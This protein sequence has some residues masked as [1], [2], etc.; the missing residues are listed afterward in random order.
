[1]QL[2]ATDRDE[3]DNAILTYNLESG[4]DGLFIVDNWT[5][6]ISLRSNLG[7]SQ[8]PLHKL[9]ISSKDRGDRRSEN[10]AIVEIIKETKL[11][12]LEF[13]S[14]GGY[15]FQIVEDHSMENAQIGREVGRTQIRSLATKITT[16]TTTPV[17]SIEYS[18]IYGDPKGNFKIDERTGIIT[19]ATKIDREVTIMYTLTVVARRGLAYGKTTANVSILDLNDNPP[20]FS[21][22]RDDIHLPENTAVGQE[23]YLSRARDKDSGINSR[24][25]YSITYNPDD[26]FRIN[27]AT[28]VVYLNR[29]IRA[30]PG[31]NIHIE[32]TATDGGTPPLSS[33]NTL[34]I[35]IADVNDH[36]PVFDHT[37]YET[38]LP[39][40]T[41]VNARFF[42]LGAS[43]ADLNENGRISYVISE[44]NSDG[45]FGI[46]PDG[47][48]FV[49]SQLDR[50][51]HD[52]YSLTISCHDHGEPSRSS[53]VPVIIRYVT[54]YSFYHL[55]SLIKFYLD[56]SLWLCRLIR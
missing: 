12:E 42:A 44:G 37:S 36:T 52:Y 18:I 32:L 4:G 22:D 26:H 54:D 28:G 16:T 43:D 5:G 23:I 29:P 27:E 53:M 13:D 49:K 38:S 45:K 7:T 9:V 19:T 40:S 56:F 1:M 21:R 24:V 35:T 48:L 3:G 6:A 8:K 51:E 15:E 31:T 47:Y 17:H 50:E 55:F 33:K 10:D 11:E 25:T 20:I 39:E 41:A 46:F 14:Y 30:E 34:T 2:S